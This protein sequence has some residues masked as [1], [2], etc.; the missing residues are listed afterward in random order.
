[1]MSGPQPTARPH[2]RPGSGLRVG[3]PR[4]LL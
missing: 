1:M 3:R 2:R 4:Q